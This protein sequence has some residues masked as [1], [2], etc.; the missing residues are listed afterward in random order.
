M[1]VSLLL[2]LL[3]VR[4]MDGRR[5]APN[6]YATPEKRETRQSK[7]TEDEVQALEDEIMRL[8]ERV[9]EMEDIAIEKDPDAITKAREKKEKQRSLSEVYDEKHE[10]EEEDLTD[11][12]WNVLPPLNMMTQTEAPPVL[13]SLWTQTAPEPSPQRLPP[14]RE[15]IAPTRSAAAQTEPPALA[16]ASTQTDGAPAVAPPPPVR[17]G[18]ATS[19][20]IAELDELRSIIELDATAPAPAAAGGLFG[21]RPRRSEHDDAWQHILGCGPVP[22][23]ASLK[24]R[25]RSFRQELDILRRN[26]DKKYDS[27]AVEEAKSSLPPPRSERAHRI[28]P[29]SLPDGTAFPLMWPPQ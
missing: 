10:D 8:R 22:A 25:A 20:L 24:Q 28:R 27:S 13:V 1:L 4:V 3:C 5:F 12:N 2:A 9:V 11:K 15:A 19:M 21:R 6:A 23:L 29:P 16:T 7:L 14:A 17:E 26:A 18:G